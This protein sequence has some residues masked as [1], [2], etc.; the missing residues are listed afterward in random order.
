MISKG[1][2]VSSNSSKKRKNEFVFTTMTNSFVRF[3]GEFE[4]NKTSFRNYLTF[5]YMAFS[6]LNC[7]FSR[8]FGPIFFC[9]FLFQSKIWKIWN[10][11]VGMS[12]KSVVNSSFSSSKQIICSLKGKYCFKLQF[13]ANTTLAK[14]KHLLR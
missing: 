6:N 5:T 10:S 4:D 1:L 8:I 14:S 7:G 9:L 12:F 2:L 13:Q 3:L 11:D